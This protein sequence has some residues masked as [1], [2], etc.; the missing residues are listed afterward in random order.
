MKA[1]RVH[2]GELYSSH[3]FAALTAQQMMLHSNKQISPCHR[4]L[5]CS[6]GDGKVGAT[7]D[8]AW[9]VMAVGRYEDDDLVWHFGLI[10][11]RRIVLSA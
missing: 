2:I 4:G 8:G 5:V 1:A 6:N 3:K 11:N 7:Q 10:L 9:S